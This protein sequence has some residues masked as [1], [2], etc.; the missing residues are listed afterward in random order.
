MHTLS[1]DAVMRLS[2]DANFL[3]PALRESRAFLSKARQGCGQGAK[4]P[5][6]K[7]GDGDREESEAG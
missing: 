3:G 2:Q 5:K 7:E 1:A 4:G 6:R